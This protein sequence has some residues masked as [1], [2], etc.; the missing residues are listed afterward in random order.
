MLSDLSGGAFVVNAVVSGRLLQLMY[1]IIIS[2]ASRP[3]DVDYGL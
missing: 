3:P 1:C 2:L